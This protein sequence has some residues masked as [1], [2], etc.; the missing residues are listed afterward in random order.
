[1][2]NRLYC[3]PP[4]YDNRNVNSSIKFLRL[5]H[6]CD[7]YSLSKTEDSTN[8]GVPITI[9]NQLVIHLHKDR[10]NTT[11]DDGES[12]EP[13]T[14]C[15]EG[16]PLNNAHERVNRKIPHNSADNKRDECRREANTR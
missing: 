6:S 15:P 11:A 5:V 4:P 2:V 7:K 13:E 8:V 14:N 3:L 16:D 12:T 10:D 1:M 9:S